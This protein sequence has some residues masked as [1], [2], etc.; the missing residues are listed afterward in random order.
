MMDRNF[1]VREHSVMEFFY[2]D[3]FSDYMPVMMPITIK[4]TA[5][6]PAYYAMDQALGR[7]LR[8]LPPFLIVDHIGM[9]H[10]DDRG[11]SLTVRYSKER[12]DEIFKNGH[13]SL[14]MMMSY[15]DKTLKEISKKNTDDLN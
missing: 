5:R 12:A 4:M 9:I 2:D 7:Q 13:D 6:N 8:F 3:S 10:R 1:K 14:E 11:S 15:I